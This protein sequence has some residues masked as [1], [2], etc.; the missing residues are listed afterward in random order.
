MGMGKME[1]A[2]GGNINALEILGEL[3]WN[4]GI[5]T[6]GVMHSKCIQQEYHAAWILEAPFVRSHGQ[7]TRPTRVASDIGCTCRRRA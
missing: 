7:S 6:R 2:S 4:Q 3:V 1:G 5:W